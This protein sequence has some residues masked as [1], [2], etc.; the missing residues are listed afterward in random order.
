MYTYSKAILY[1]HLAYNLHTI[2]LIKLRTL[3]YFSYK[4]N[5]H[6]YIM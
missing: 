1:I 3:L 5:I 2:K 6:R 4:D